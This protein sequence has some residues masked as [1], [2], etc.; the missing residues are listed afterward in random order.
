VTD[1]ER[2]EMAVLYKLLRSSVEQNRI[3]N[4]VRLN[5]QSFI[6]LIVGGFLV[7][8][9]FF[10]NI[11]HSSIIGGV[12]YVHSIFLSSGGNAYSPIGVLQSMTFCVA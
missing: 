9:E 12:K 11:R 4:G 10:G 5:G 8:V 7:H 2:R 3:K 1:G 6:N